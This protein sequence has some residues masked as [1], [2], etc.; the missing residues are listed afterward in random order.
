MLLAEKFKPDIKPKRLFHLV[1]RLELQDS[2]LLQAERVGESHF[3]KYGHPY[4]TDFVFNEN[5]LHL[6]PRLLKLGIP[7]QRLVFLDT[8]FQN[9]PMSP[10]NVSLIDSVKLD[11]VHKNSQVRRIDGEFAPIYVRVQAYSHGTYEHEVCLHMLVRGIGLCRITFNSRSGS[12][13][14]P[15]PLEVDRRPVYR[16]DSWGKREKTGR[17][18]LLYTSKHLENSEQDSYALCRVVGDPANVASGVFFFDDND[19]FFNTYKDVIS[20][21]QKERRNYLKS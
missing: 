3:L 6:L 16:E 5:Q 17:Y 10:T 9:I 15:W 21:Q 18:Q 13:R 4:V 7:L 12:S 11:R 19:Q 8:F 14:Y 2:V 1:K 20:Y